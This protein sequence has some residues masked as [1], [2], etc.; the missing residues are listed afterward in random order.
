LPVPMNGTQRV[1]SRWSVRLT[2]L[3]LALALV[4]AVGMAANPAPASAAGLKVVV[5]VGP[6]EGSTAKYISNGKR[7]AAQARGYGANVIEIYSPNATWAKVSAAAQG[8]NIFI[9][10]GH[11]NGYPSFHYGFSR[12]RKDGVGLNALAG[13][14]NSN[15][16]YYGEWYVS[17]LKLA[18][19]AVVILNHLCYASG[20]SEPGQPDPSRAVAMRRVDN[21]GAGFLRSGA[22]A[23]FAEGTTDASY[24]LANLFTTTRTIGQIFQSSPRWDGR[25]DFQFQSRR[26][27]IFKAWMDPKAPTKYYRS[28]VGDLGLTAKAVRGD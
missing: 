3:T 25:Y 16:K 21:Y 23:V 9:Y 6:V 2:V 15:T 19:N 17:R 14:G 7:Y 4:A 13:H 10:I 22:R 12:Y 26:T 18:A 5:V 27:P 24:I 11:G 28:V 20:N 8:A 1:S